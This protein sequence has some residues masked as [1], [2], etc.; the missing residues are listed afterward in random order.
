MKIIMILTMMYSVSACNQGVPKQEFYIDVINDVTDKHLLRPQAQAILELYNLSE[1]KGSSGYF[2]YSEIRDI[3]MVPTT[4]IYLPDEEGTET[5]NT[6]NEPLFREGLILKFFDSIRSTLN[7]RGV[8]TDSS[9]LNNSECFHSICNE[10][11]LLTEGISAK[12]VLLIFSNLYEHS[13]ILSLYSEKYRKIL[14]DNPN[15]IKRIFIDTH[16]LPDSLTGITAIFVY[17]PINRADDQKYNSIV[18]IYKNLLQERGAKV[19]IQ[20]SNSQY[21]L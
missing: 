7:N 2:R 5:R 10:L 16:M 6:K 4:T 11:K 15:K 21:S 20:A 18:A 12:K 13:N 8:V 1:I 9:I 14:T 19:I 3:T 17:Q